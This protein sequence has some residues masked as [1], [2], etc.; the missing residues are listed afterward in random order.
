MGCS[1]AGSTLTY[2]DILN[3]NF[4]IFF[5]Q[6]KR[7]LL[8]LKEDKVTYKMTPSLLSYVLYFLKYFASNRKLTRK[9]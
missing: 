6:M 9:V 5:T 4:T 7:D 8:H 2:S 1:S 3:H